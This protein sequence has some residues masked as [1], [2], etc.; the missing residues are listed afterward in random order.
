MD[1]LNSPVVWLLLSFFLFYVLVNIF[2][3]SKSTNNQSEP[4]SKRSQERTPINA[5]NATQVKSAEQ[6]FFKGNGQ[7]YQFTVADCFLTKDNNIL[8]HQAIEN[9]AQADYH[10]SIGNEDSARL[11]YQKTAFGTP[12]MNKKQKAVIKDEIIAFVK[13]DSK[14]QK[15]LPRLQGFINDSPGIKQTELYIKLG[16]S[17]DANKEALRYVLY[18]ADV[19]SDVVRVK[20]GRSYALYPQGYIITDVDKPKPK[21]RTKPFG[22]ISQMLTAYNLDANQ[23]SYIKELIKEYGDSLTFMNLTKEDKQYF[24]NLIGSKDEAF[25]ILH[26]ISNLT[27]ALSRRVDL[28]DDLDM[29]LACPYLKFRASL[30]DNCPKECTDNDNKVFNRRHDFIAS[31][32]PCHRLDCAC[33]LNGM[34]IEAIQADNLGTPEGGW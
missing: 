28:F 12:S 9:L 5:N 10:H 34:S 1:F 26:S 18:F 32:A 16:I 20:K 4:K 3:K 15:W 30:D 22:S 6:S 14:Y 8:H 17:D 29:V 21:K 27:Y 11:Y 31:H 24:T 13:T 2:D 23:K 33:S 25:A 19:L 7:K